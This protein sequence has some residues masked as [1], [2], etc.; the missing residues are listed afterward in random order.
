[1]YPYKIHI[2]EM[3]AGIYDRLDRQTYIIK[4]FKISKS[5]MKLHC[6]VMF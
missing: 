1:M 5:K 2:Y 6:W 4:L 3:M